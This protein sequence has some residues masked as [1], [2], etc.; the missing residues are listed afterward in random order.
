MIDK[1]LRVERKVSAG[2]LASPEELRQSIQ[3]RKNGAMFNYLREV[4]VILRQLSKQA[5]VI[6]KG[7]CASSGIECGLECTDTDITQTE[8]PKTDVDGVLTATCKESHCSNLGVL[9]AQEVFKA[10]FT[11]PTK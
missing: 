10:A 11:K 9:A 1:P 3:A 7:V 2:I 6:G 5:E 4:P 8:T